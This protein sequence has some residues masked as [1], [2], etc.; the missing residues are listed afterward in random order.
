[1]TIKFL[2]KLLRDQRG[3]ETLEYALIAGLIAVIALFIYLDVGWQRTLQNRLT[4]STAAGDPVAGGSGNGGC[5]IPPC[6]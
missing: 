4:N 1:M 3:V 2:P 5:P 6:G